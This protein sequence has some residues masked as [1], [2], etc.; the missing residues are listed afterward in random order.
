MNEVIT[1]IKDPFPYLKIENLYTEEELELIGDEL[2]FLNHKSKL[3]G[4]EDTGSAKDSSDNLL[5]ENRGLFLDDLYKRREISNIL[6]INRKLFNKEYLEAYA[7]L[8]FGYKSILEC[9]QD[10]TLISYYEN[11]GYYKPHKDNSMHTALTWF[12]EVPKMFEGGDLFFPE[13]NEKIE[14]QQNMT[15]IFP[16]FV[17]HSVEEVKMKE[18]IS[19]GLGRYC[20]SQF[21]TVTL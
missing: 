7:S 11:G 8:S 9:N 1:K 15:V 21:M 12:F 14:I 10:T 18:N 16:S 5:K 19:Q 17:L 4:P 20:M 2:I 6:S 13:Y 3:E